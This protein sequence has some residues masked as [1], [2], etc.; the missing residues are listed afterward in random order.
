MKK[1]CTFVAVLTVIFLF[2]GVSSAQNLFTEDFN[3]AA[4]QLLTANGWTAHSGTG[5]N[6][7]TVTTTGGANGL[8]TTMGGYAGDNVGLSVTLAASG[9]DDNKPLSAPVSS[10]TVYFA[11]MVKVT[12]AGTGGYFLHLGN[13]TSNFASKL[14]VQ[15]STPSGGFNFGI[16]KTSE[17]TVYE[18]TVRNFGETYLVVMKYTYGAIENVYINPTLASEPVSPTFSSTGTADLAS[19]F[20]VGAYIRQGSSAPI[21]AV[22]G[23]RVGLTWGDVL[24]P[25]VSTLYASPSSLSGFTYAISHGPSASQSFSLSGVL[26]TGAP[27]TLTVTGSTNFEVSSNNTTFGPTASISY[28][29]ATL[30]STNVYVRLKTG[31]APASYGPENIAITGGGA[32]ELDVPVSGLVVSN[33]ITVSTATL[34]G[35]TYH[36]LSDGGP[37]ASQNYSLSGSNLTA[38][39]ITVTAPTNFEVSTD[40]SSFSPSLTVSYTPPTL[41]STTIYVRLKSGLT[42]NT[43]SGNVTNAG[44]GAFTQNVAVSGTVVTQTLS[45]SIYTDVSLSYVSGSGPSGPADYSLAGSNLTGFPGV[46]TITAPTNFEVSVDGGTTYSSSG[47]VAYTGATLGTT[48][49]YVRLAG[50]LA[51]G[52]Y[53][54]GTFSFAGGGANTVN[55]TLNGKVTTGGLLLSDNFEYTAGGPGDTLNGRGGWVAHSGIGQNAIPVTSPGLSYSNL[56]GSGIGNAV[57]LT[58]VG[59]DVNHQFTGISG[60]SPAIYASAMVNV[61]PGVSTTGDYFIHF[62][63]QGTFDFCAR[64]FIK[65][66]GSGTAFYFGISKGSGGT[67]W[68]TG[69][70]SYNT[71][72]LIVLKYNFVAGASNDYCNLFINPAIGGTEPAANLTSAS[73]GT[74]E[75]SISGIFLRKG[76]TAANCPTVQVDGIKVGQTWAQVTPAA[77]ETLTLT[78]FI[79]GPTNSGGTAMKTDV[80][81]VAVT[82]ELHNSS[83]YALVEAKTG[84]LSSI[85]VGTFTFTTAADATPYY[86]VVKSANTIETWSAAPQ[87][88][89][90]GA[91]SYNFTTSADQAYGSNMVQKG[92]KW[93]IFS[94]DVSKDATNIVDGSD[95][96]AID[97]DNTYGVT[98]N[99]VTDITGDG[100]VDGSD[101]INVDNNN[102]YGISRQAPGGAP[103]AAKRVMR[104][105]LTIKQNIK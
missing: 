44:G 74:D 63:D 78:A 48:P 32:T 12:S 37:S 16:A 28:S 38:G 5:T 94:G 31:L 34:S 56:A 45:P 62:S 53:G 20:L 47:T 99:A 58:N 89:T 4:G 7:I 39:P 17:T 83:T 69:T 36:T 1:I 50:G 33:L 96:I 87:S 54:P 97:N 55:F 92:S 75:V 59:E 15:G 77:G 25:L 67:V 82:V 95:V 85:G 23:I 84:N 42:A 93:C 68:S 13:G 102:T 21:L 86:I 73:T 30:G 104:P 81:P 105:G 6:A 9:E 2:T 64:T 65:D 3:Y 66:N 79:E 57:T 80:W 52:T 26:L 72:H 103:I 70:Y 88:F 91:L 61:A 35:F 24:P 76:N 49:I 90:A 101:V 22:D 46:I 40:N 27:G 71:T 41:G 10:G 19:P 8:S 100:I 29:A 11:A 14:W 60:T 98:D 18:S 43:Y 51:N